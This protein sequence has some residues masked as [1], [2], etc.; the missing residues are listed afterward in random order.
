ME[1]P[2][3]EQSF[4]H[5]RCATG[6]IEIGRHEPASGLQVDEQWN[7]AVDPV[8]VINAE[9]DAGLARDSEQMQ[10]RV[11]GPAG[12]RHRSDGVLQRLAGDNLLRAEI[13]LQKINYQ[14][15]APNSDIV[16]ARV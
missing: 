5:K 7:L 14:L 2:R 1:Q 15:A 12:R 4:G 16:L 8:E 10:H 3:F 6:R 11:R 9:L 13:I